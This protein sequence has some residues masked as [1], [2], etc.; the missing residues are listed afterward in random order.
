MHY[1]DSIIQAYRNDQPISKEKLYPNIK[2]YHK[3]DTKRKDIVN[4]LNKQLQ[5]IVEQFPV[6]NAHLWSLLFHDMDDVLD[7][8]Y[9]C[10]V[11]GSDTLSTQCTK[12]ED[13]YLFIDLICV[14]NYTRIVSQMTYILKNHIMY[15]ITRICILKKYPLH[16]N[17]Y[18]SLLDA[19]AF[20]HGLS[21]YISWN[22]A[23]MKYKFYTEAYEKRKEQAFG[24][25]AQAMQVDNKAMQH[26]I[27]LHIRTGDLWNQFPAAAGMF[28]FDDVYREL[29][30]KGIYQL[31]EKGPKGFVKH[32]FA[33]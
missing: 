26:K 7:H 21:Y 9:I 30:N 17:N 16:S 2:N 18:A 20:I 22:E 25:L 5:H 4:E 23:C 13:I 14:A 12:K 32:I 33:S 29:G 6:F 10:P 8:I 15:E 3:P 27:L 19:S 31:F 24:L 1:N 28:Y 11:V